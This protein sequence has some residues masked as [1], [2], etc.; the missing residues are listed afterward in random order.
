[1]VIHLQSYKNEPKPVGIENLILY[2]LA[3]LLCV[4]TRTSQ[5]NK[6]VHTTIA[7]KIMGI[8]EVYKIQRPNSAP[9]QNNNKSILPELS[10][11]EGCQINYDATNSI[12][13]SRNKKTRFPH[14]EQTK[15][16]SEDKWK[17]C[18]VVIEKMF[19]LI[20]LM[21][22]LSAVGLLV[23]LSTGNTQALHELILQPDDHSFT[24]H[25]KKNKKKTKHYFK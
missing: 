18:S 22:N 21:A 23:Y 20:W 12:G 25:Q 4:R 17:S 6:K 19:F 3:N 16:S 13:E 24:S 15:S 8:R 2:H 7:S 11:V 14:P 10:V 1:M 5:N 9:F